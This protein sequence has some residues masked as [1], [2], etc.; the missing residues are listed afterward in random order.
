MIPVRKNSFSTLISLPSTRYN[1]QFN[2]LLRIVQPEMPSRI[3]S[4]L[5]HSTSSTSSSSPKK[6]INISAYNLEILLLK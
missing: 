4:S 3:S 2:Q 6:A 1:L 5:L